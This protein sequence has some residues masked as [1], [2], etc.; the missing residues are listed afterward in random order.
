MGRS[1]YKSIITNN[2]VGL[3]VLYFRMLFPHVYKQ[4]IISC[5]NMKENCKHSTTSRQ[6]EQNASTH[7]ADPNNVLLAKKTKQ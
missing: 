2:Q 3:I 1:K 4:Q 5:H 7:P 6:R